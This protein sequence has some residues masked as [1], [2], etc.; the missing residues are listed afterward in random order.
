MKKCFVVC[1]IGDENTP[2]RKR[3]DQLFDYIITPACKECN[4]EP[5]RVDK[6]NGSDSITETILKYLNESD[7]VIADLTDHN[8]NA[9]FEIG[10][11]FSLG[12]N[13][14]NLCQKGTKIP[15]DIASIRT[16]DYILNDLAEAD[17]SKKR[18]IATIN[19]LNF[20]DSPI[21]EDNSATSNNSFNSQILQELFKIQDSI[22]DL[23]E[24]ISI[25]KTDTAAISVLAD[26]LAATSSKTAPDAAIAQVLTNLLNEPAK[27]DSLLGLMEKYPKLK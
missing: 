1:P 5:I 26:K 10:Y 2:T 8:P 19:S 23:N 7:L 18:L 11:R 9:F 25:N 4:F 21:K 27:F 14:I 13:I 3:S 6:I 15:F 17:K 16:L 24:Q 22:K 20:D 12:K